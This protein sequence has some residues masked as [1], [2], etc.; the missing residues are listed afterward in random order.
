MK[1]VFVSIVYCFW[2]FDQ[3]VLGFNESFMIFKAFLNNM[4]LY[5]F[6]L[7]GFIPVIYF[8]GAS[9]FLRWSLST[10][11]FLVVCVK[12]TVLLYAA[13]IVYKLTVTL[14]CSDEEALQ[15][16]DKLVSRYYFPPISFMLHH[17]AC[18][19]VFVRVRARVS[20]RLEKGGGV[21][22][23]PNILTCKIK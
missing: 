22:S 21:R 6:L 8:A 18:W 15:A 13:C 16:I 10:V 5:I 20:V 19:I 9:F 1:F 7:F 14:P 11:K 17:Y 23:T 4:Y 2:R 12:L 3:H